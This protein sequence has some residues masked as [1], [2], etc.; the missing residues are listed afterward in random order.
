MT[1]KCRAM[2]IM[3]IA[4]SHFVIS[5]GQEIS[6]KHHLYT[7]SSSLRA[8]QIPCFRIFTSQ[9]FIQMTLF[10]WL[11]CCPERHLLPSSHNYGSESERVVVAY[12][13]CLENQRHMTRFKASQYHDISSLVSCDHLKQINSLTIYQNFLNTFDWF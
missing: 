6:S 9:T 1:D 5:I 4:V 13:F 12:G 2:V 11:H 3:D 7:V 8:G 10:K